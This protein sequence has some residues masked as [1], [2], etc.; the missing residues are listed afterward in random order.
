[1]KCEACEVEVKGIPFDNPSLAEM[2]LC[3]DCREKYWAAWP[4]VFFWLAGLSVVFGFIACLAFLPGDPGYGHEWKSI[5][6]LPAITYFALGLVNAALFVAIGRA[7]QYLH[8]IAKNSF[9]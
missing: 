4:L 7:L 9:K 6:Y 2:T 8:I 5:A 1:M 3:T